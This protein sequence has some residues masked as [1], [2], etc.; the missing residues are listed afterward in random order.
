[1]KT[2]L[3]F[4]VPRRLAVSALASV[5][6]LGTSIAATAMAPRL[7][8]VTSPPGGQSPQQTTTPADGAQQK[9]TFTSFDVQGAGTGPGQGTLVGQIIPNGAILGQ[10]VDANNVF[11]G[12][13]RAA[14][15]KITTFDV[16][17]AGAGAFQG[18][19]PA[20]G[21]NNEEVITGDYVDANNAMHGFL[22]A[23]DG[24]ITKFDVTGAGTGAGQGTYGADIDPAGEVSG[25]YIDAN[26]VSHGFLR[27]PNGVI[28]KYDAPGAG[29]GAG[30]GTSGPTDN[31]MNPAGAVTGYVTDASGAT[32]GFVRAPDGT[33]TT[34][35]VPGAVVTAPLGINPAGTITGLFVTVSNV[36]GFVRA[37]NGG[38]TTFEAPGA[39]TGSGQGTAPEGINPG[40]EV[41]G[42][43]VDANSVNH[44]F[45]RSADGRIT[46]FDVPGAG[47]GAGQ[48]TVPDGNNPAGAVA[49]YYTDANNVNHGFVGIP[50]DD[51]RGPTAGD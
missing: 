34:F 10:S 48:G 3:F 27:P 1:M 6:L 28:F 38:I 11:H 9:F 42:Y 26:N 49:G 12:F 19:A 51:H 47:A 30:Q 25:F 43:Y 35:D 20:A 4:R 29:A 16:P 2:S 39:G 32:H 33:I 8:T 21:M 50:R 36:F 7:S 41:V 31:G 14:D 18:T 15:G 5:G 17:G 24:K 40:G 44:G 46:T 37:P 23:R 45:V 22:R 13:L